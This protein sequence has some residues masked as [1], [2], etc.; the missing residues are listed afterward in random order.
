MDYIELAKIILPYWPLILCGLA[1]VGIY[2]PAYDIVKKIL[3]IFNGEKV[4]DEKKEKE[5]VID[6][7]MTVKEFTGKMAKQCDVKIAALKDKPMETCKKMM[8]NI[9]ATEVKCRARVLECVVRSRI[10]QDSF[11]LQF[12]FILEH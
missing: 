10:V 7:Q 6:G 4:V 9:G 3:N 8:S 2:P 1:L 11:L 5:K 12:P